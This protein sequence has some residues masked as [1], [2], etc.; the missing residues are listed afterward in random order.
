MEDITAVTMKMLYSFKSQTVNSRGAP[1]VG[2]PGC[3][4]ALKNHKNRNLKNRL[5][6]HYDTEHFT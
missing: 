2:L 5:C 4:Q 6:R 3:M 1:K